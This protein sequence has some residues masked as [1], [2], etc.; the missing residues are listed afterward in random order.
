MSVLGQPLSVLIS[1]PCPGE[2]G[3]GE[4]AL[5]GSAI[6]AGRGAAPQSRGQKRA[7]VTVVVLVNHT[8]GSRLY[9]PR[10]AAVVRCALESG[11]DL[12]GCPSA[13]PPMVN[14]AGVQERGRCECE[15]DGPPAH[16]SIWAP[17]VD[18]ELAFLPTLEVITWNKYF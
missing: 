16:L 8:S 5:R 2:T 3:V 10:G 12:Q 4:S 15:G 17:C 13:L 1:N 18:A 9:G 14:R 11:A 7:F 6:R